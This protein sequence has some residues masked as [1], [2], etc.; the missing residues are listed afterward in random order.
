MSWKTIEL[1]GDLI[2][3]EWPDIGRFRIV[4]IDAHPLPHKTVYDVKIQT[5]LPCHNDCHDTPFWVSLE[6]A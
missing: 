6:G 4:H 3:A 2:R 1:V 5:G